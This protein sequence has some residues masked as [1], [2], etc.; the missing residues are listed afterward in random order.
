MLVNAGKCCA[1]VQLYFV[2]VQPALCQPQPIVTGQR[3]GRCACLDSARRSSQMPRSPLTI[4]S[5][6]SRPW[7]RSKGAQGVTEGLDLA[8][9]DPIEPQTVSSASSVSPVSPVSRRRRDDGKIVL[10]RFCS[11]LREIRE[12]FT[13]RAWYDPR[14]RTEVKHSS[15]HISNRYPPAKKAQK[16][17]WHRHGNPPT[18]LVASHGSA[19]GEPRHIMRYLVV[20]QDR[21]TRHGMA[22][23]T[24]PP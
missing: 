17:R 14:E 12:L 10:D 16:K 24:P 18:A 22:S 3:K 9:Q 21:Q 20:T 8:S 2:L 11:R 1:P 13:S 15:S 6:R 5:P 19:I 4:I 23:R 7:C